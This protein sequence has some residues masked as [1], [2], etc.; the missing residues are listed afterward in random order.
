MKDFYIS[1]LFSFLI[2]LSLS[3]CNS[4]EDE[5]DVPDE[6]NVEYT[7]MAVAGVN[8]LIKN[9]W[10]EGE[11]IRPTWGGINIADNIS[12][13][14]GQL[15][16]RAMMIFPMYHLYQ[17]NKNSDLHSKLL[18]EAN[19]LKEKYDESILTQAGHHFNTALDDCAWNVMM[20][21]M[22]YELTDD[23]WYITIAKGLINSSIERWT[24]P[25]DG[26]LY[27]ADNKNIKSL[28]AAGMVLSMIDIYDLTG[29]QEWLD[30]AKFH[31]GWMVSILGRTDGLYW[32]DAD[33]AGP[34]GKDDPGRI[35]E[36]SSVSFLAGNQAMCLIEKRLYDIEKDE[37]YLTRIKKTSLAICT[38]YNRNG[39][40]LNDRDAWTNGVFMSDFA[41]MIGANP[42]LGYTNADLLLATA[43]SIVAKDVTS[44][45]HYGGSWQGPTGTGSKWTDGGSLPQQVMTSGTTVHV[46]VAA[47]ILNELK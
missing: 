11:G 18:F 36:A 8:N 15:W 47:A 13:K 39:I 23:A 3:S 14:R 35:N 31:Y 9:F 42:D 30:K 28:Y 45:G 32:T 38:I 6:P 37:S 12:D 41:K 22:F 7:Q 24:D 27:Y 19:R 21:M 33:D 20:F 26:A 34:L 1:L 17:L 43:R 46:L 25:S 2:S 16:E 29:E 40:Y 4:S 5:N 10:E 44:D